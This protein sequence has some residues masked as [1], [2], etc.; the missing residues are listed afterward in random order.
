MAEAAAATVAWLTSQTGLTITLTS[1]EA[2]A[3]ATAV[4]LVAATPCVGPCVRRA[5]LNQ[6]PVSLSADTGP[7]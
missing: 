6:S 2:F 5:A 1:F 4:E 3:I 7:R